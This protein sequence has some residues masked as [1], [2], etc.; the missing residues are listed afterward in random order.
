MWIRNVMLAAGLLIC[1][2]ITVVAS[3]V[4]NT[5]PMSSEQFKQAESDKSKQDEIA[6]RRKNANPGRLTLQNVEDWLDKHLRASI[7]TS[8]T[9]VVGG[10]LYYSECCDNWWTNQ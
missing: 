5:E 6:K 7:V 3:D 10:A 2:E 1:T 9:I 4:S 8:V